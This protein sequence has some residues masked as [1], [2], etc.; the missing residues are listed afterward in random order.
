MHDV[1]CGRHL[2][3]RPP[4]LPGRADQGLLLWGRAVVPGVLGERFSRDSHFTET[5]SAQPLFLP[6][7]P[8]PAGCV[9]SCRWQSTD[10]GVSPLVGTSEWTA[11]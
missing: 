2:G 9:P 4:H 10:I 8:A 11:S 7:S 6:S 5:N 1:S 3:D